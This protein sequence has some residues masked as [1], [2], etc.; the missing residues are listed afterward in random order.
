MVKFIPRLVSGLLFGSALLVMPF[1]AG[2][3]SIIEVTPLAHDF[4]AVPVGAESATHTF[5][6]ANTNGT[7]SLSRPS[8]SLTSI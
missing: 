1:A 7:F 5:T 3:Q 2:A 6:I 4:G 8:I